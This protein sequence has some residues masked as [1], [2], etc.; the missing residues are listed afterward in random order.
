MDGTYK[1]WSNSVYYW[2][3]PTYVWPPSGA[4][5]GRSTSSARGYH[6]GSQNALPVF[7]GLELPASIQSQSYA[8]QARSDCCL[9]Q[10][11]NTFTIE[12]S[13][14]RKNWKQLTRAV[15]W[16]SR[17]WVE[18]KSFG[19]PNYVLNAGY[20]MYRIKVT[21]SNGGSWMSLGDLKLFG[22][23]TDRVLSYPP[24]NVAA[25]TSWSKPSSETGDWVTT[26]S[27]S[28]YMD[29]TIK[30]G[31][32]LFIIGIILPMFG[33]L[34]CIR[35]AI[36]FFGTWIPHRSQ[37]AIVFFVGL[38]LPASIQLQSYALQARSDCCLDQQPNTFTIEGSNDRKNWKQLDSRSGVVF[39][40]LGEIK[41]FG[42][43]NYVL[44]A[45]YRMCRIKVTKSNGGSWMSLG[46]LKLFGHQ[47][48]RVLSYPPSNVAASTSWSK[49]SSETGGLEVTVG[50]ILATWMVLIKLGRTLFIIGIILPMFG[51]LRVHSM[52]DQLLRHVDT[53]Q[54]VKTLC[55]FLSV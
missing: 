50:L 29:G 21:K 42:V 52:G 53:T 37:N 41:S 16:Y 55:Q 15:E 18:I 3:N 34:R 22:H 13:N 51:H 9:D 44:N 35:W 47:T 2:N 5:D 20:R 14:D 31:R 36:N 32:T 26:V 24:S 49:P 40:N 27:D 48:D 25:S 11:P 39:S 8:L 54:G 7:V 23:Q 6:T 17:I 38:E 46:D 33:H 45:G 12:G 10:Q 19:V 28:G 43:P 4:F 30:L 1:A